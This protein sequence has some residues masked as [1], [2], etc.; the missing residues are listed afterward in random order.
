MGIQEPFSNGNGAEQGI[1]VLRR[2]GETDDFVL[3]ANLQG[4]H[5]YHHLVQNPPVVSVVPAEGENLVGGG[6]F[7]QGDAVV[8]VQPVDDLLEGGGLFQL[9]VEVHQ[10]HVL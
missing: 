3:V 5:S 2:K 10:V 9:K 1:P 7:G 4:G 6:L 8:G